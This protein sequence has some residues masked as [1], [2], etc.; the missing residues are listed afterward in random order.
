MRAG[1][2]GFLVP[3]LASEVYKLTLKERLEMGE[4][5]LS[6]TNGRVSVFAGLGDKNYNL[7]RQLLKSCL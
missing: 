3:A 4:A 1:V 7:S 2:A 6:I 5:T